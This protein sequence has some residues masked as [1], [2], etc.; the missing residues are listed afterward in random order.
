MKL[1]VG[2]SSSLQRNIDPFHSPEKSVVCRYRNAI[3]FDDRTE[4]DLALKQYLL[5][6]SISEGARI[7]SLMT[8][9]DVDVDILDE[10]SRMA[11]GSLKSIDGC[12][13]A[14][15]CRM[16]KVDRVTFESGGNTGSA[17][18]KYLQ[19]A[20]METF[21]FCPMANIDLLDSRLFQN[22]L[23]HLIGIE[24]RRCVKEFTMQ[25]ARIEGIRHIP[26]KSW[27]NAA[28]MF[29][30]LFILEQLLLV[31]K[32][33]W[34]SQT[35]S[36]GFGP[37]GI[38][39]VLKEFQAEMGGLPRF[40]GVQ[41]EANCPMFEAWKCNAIG[42]RKND[43]TKEEKLLTK[44]MYDE[45]PQTYKTFEDL[46]QLLQ[47]TRGDLLTVNTEEFG[48]YQRPSEVYGHVLDLLQAQGISISLRSGRILEKTGL[49]ALVG[50]L[51]A[52]DAGVITSGSRVLCCL[53]S[54]VSDADGNA[55]PEE[56]LHR[57][58]DILQY[59]ETISGGKG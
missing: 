43:Y 44:I 46:Q 29:R 11:T 34:L 18:T 20:G 57:T 17:L 40:L 58:Q 38:Y 33:D 49:I 37:I 8:Y 31:R 35:I 19:K 36:A 4:Y 21:F 23:T 52:I 1:L 16:E 45:T 41:Q 7:V 53:T 26:E 51:K 3:Q 55:Q 30:G 56:T 12:L 6:S 24:D 59:A 39:N 14:A 48:S 42:R 9:K 22:R 50:T 27:R 13:A 32:Y 54:G 15:F 25:F 28:A 10:T 5:E 2:N 47:L